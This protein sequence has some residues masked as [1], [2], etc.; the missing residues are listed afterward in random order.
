MVDAAQLVRADAALAALELAEEHVDALDP[1]GLAFIERGFAARRTA[2]AQAA[3]TIADPGC[4]TNAIVIDGDG[5]AVSLIESVSAPYGSGVVLERTGIL[6]NNRMGGFNAKPGHPN[7]V[8]PAKRPANTL[9]PCIVTRAGELALS[10]GTP[11]T[12]GQTCTLTQFLA[13]VYACGQDPA[14]AVDAP[15]WSV[16]FQ[17]NLVVERAMAPELRAAVLAATEGAHA[18]PTG[19]I[20][21]G[22][23]KA[24]AVTA[25][26]FAGVADYRRA[27]TTAGW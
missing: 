25:S 15:R 3:P 11:G 16:D 21:F 9:A 19:W 5:L 10:L 4:T 6:L 27:A 18:M 12:V 17:G 8:A 22:S 23:I 7:S 2:Y 1:D 24:A 13:R 26:G 20:S 14:A